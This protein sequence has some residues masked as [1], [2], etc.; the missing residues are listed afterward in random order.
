MRATHRLG[1]AVVALLAAVLL[2][3]CL[4]L[5]ADL[6]VSDD[7]TVDGTF[8]FGVDKQL[9]ALTGQDASS[10]TEQVQRDMETDPPTA[11]TIS[12]EPY[13]DDDFVGATVTFRD[14]PLDDF[15]V[16]GAEGPD[17]ALT[18]T[19][20]G[21]QFE[22]SGELDFE[23][24]DLPG[25]EGIPNIDELLASSEPQLSIALTFPGEV[26]S[27]NGSIDGC[28]VSWEPAL[29]E[30][31]SFEAT[32]NDSGGCTESIKW[33]A[34][35]LIGIGVLV[36]IGGIVAIV[37]TIK[38]EKSRGPT[39]PPTG[40]ATAAASGAAVTGAA[41]D[42]LPPESTPL[43][44]PP[45]EPQ[46]PPSPPSRPDLPAPTAPPADTG[47]LPD[48]PGPVP[49]ADDAVDSGS[50]PDLPDLPGHPPDT[51][52]FPPPPPSGPAGFPPPE[53]KD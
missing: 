1:A 22:V 5:D 27:S 28:T 51:G 31:T 35:I 39:S 13:E 3:G 44:M 10:L 47:S 50:V 20:D 7:D 36:L 15:N 53:P 43:T 52:S 46:T 34:W 19:H 8:V 32:A 12:A 16:P 2:G 6:T 11:G 33:W 25:G 40:P 18:I 48:L 42:D 49:D 29:T 45:P 41:T 4:K 26:T 37:R 38:K 24:G 9:L 14:V 21:D 30:A 23:L 17:N